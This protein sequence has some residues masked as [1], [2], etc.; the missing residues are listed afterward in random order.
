LSYSLQI[1]VPIRFVYWQWEKGFWRHF[2]VYPLMIVSSQCM[3]SLKWLQ[4]DT[5]SLQGTYLSYLLHPP[6][7]EFFKVSAVA[8]MAQYWSGTSLPLSAKCGE[9]HTLP[10]PLEASCLPQR[11][12][13]LSNPAPLP[14]GP[15]GPLRPWHQQNHRSTPDF[16][17]K[18][19]ELSTPATPFLQLNWQLPIHAVSS[20]V[21]YYINLI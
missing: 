19:P 9:G 18:I 20:L 12:L 17:Q 6:I 8:S 11:G 21:F 16:P 3:A 7:L 1:T 5:T 15:L 14:A 4:S 2:T 13:Y 10:L